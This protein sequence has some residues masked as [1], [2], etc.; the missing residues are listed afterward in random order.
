MEI[1]DI[2]RSNGATP[3]TIA[4][5]DGHVH[6][7]LDRAKLERL[8]NLKHRKVSRGDLAYVLS[9]VCWDVRS[10]ASCNDS[11]PTHAGFVW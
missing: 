6:V 8:A 5:L 10:T 3:A 7:G 4:V 2:V 11:M 9:K 1:E